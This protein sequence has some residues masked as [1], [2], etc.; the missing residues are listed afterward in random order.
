M[1]KRIIALV[2]MTIGLIGTCSAATVDGNWGLSFEK[3]G[4]K[5]RGN[6]APDRLKEF[7]AYF[8]G[9]GDE[10][11]VYLTFDAGY[12]NGHTETILDVLKE[13]EVPATFF[14]VGTYIR[15]NPEIVSRMVQEGHIV[16]NHTMNHPDMSAISDI[17]SFEGE[18]KQTQDCYKEVTGEDIPMYYRPPQGKFSENNLKMA[19]ELGYK[20][21]FWSLAYVDW[22]TDDQPDPEF[23]FS[24]LM[25]RLHP[26]MVL[27]LH[28][29]SQT[30]SGILKEL[31][32]KYKDEGYTFESIDH[33]VGS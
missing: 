32:Q 5:P 14:L 6:A 21:I 3:D 27:L 19:K 17:K 15:D 8:V 25:P 24:K 12:E 26:G 28:S 18:L 13:T 16:G 30:N 10:K 1:K 2:L 22:N 31:I 7:D 29:T 20:T 9:E 11:V 23:A 4:E 33:L